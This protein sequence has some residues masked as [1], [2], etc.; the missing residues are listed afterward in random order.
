MTSPQDIK[1]VTVILVGETDDGMIAESIC[2]ILSVA[3]FR[4]AVDARDSRRREM[5]F[6]ANS[7]RVEDAPHERS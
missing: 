3:G 6:V 7:V 1:G 4:R 2:E 5:V